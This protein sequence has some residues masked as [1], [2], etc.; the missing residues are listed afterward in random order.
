MSSFDPGVV[1]TLN[2]R[3]GIFFGFLVSGG[4]IAVIIF[5]KWWR[6]QNRWEK[7]LSDISDFKEIM[8]DVKGSDTSKFIFSPEQEKKKIWRY[9][10]E[11][12][13]LKRLHIV[14]ACAIVFLG[15]Q[16][17][18]SILIDMALLALLST[19]WTVFWG[20]KNLSRRRTSLFLD[21]LPEAIDIIIRGAQL[22]KS[23]SQNLAIVGDEMP[24]PTGIVFRKLAHQLNIG[25]DLEESFATIREISKVK[26]MQILATTLALQKEFGGEYAK[27]LENLS[28]LLRDRRAHNLKTQALTSEARLS[29]KIVSAVT[30]AVIGF[31]AIT[32]D[33]QLEFLLHDQAGHHL[34][35]Y[36]LASNGIGLISV[37]FFLKGVR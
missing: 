36:C 3:V 1:S 20:I 27:I 13:W 21:Q 34:L 28:R 26:E 16:F 22:G 25:M 35:L 10:I 17:P 7:R 2:L 30:I 24:A 5:R 37:S 8:P 31:L 12:E 4:Y 15:F 19:T 14:C 6:K 32:S 29:A 23:I 9:L 18:G 33:T 11:G